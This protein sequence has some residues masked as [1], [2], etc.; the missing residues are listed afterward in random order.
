MIIATTYS[1]KSIAQGIATKLS[2]K[3]GLEYQVVEGKSGWFVQEV[4]RTQEPQPQKKPRKTRVKTLV[5]VIAQL[6][7]V[8]PSYLTLDVDGREIYVWKEYPKVLMIDEES[9][10]ATFQV[11]QFYAEKKGLTFQAVV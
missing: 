7:A 6:K 4:T 2:R 1:K 10:T 11:P 9:K 8:S 3:T 5:Q